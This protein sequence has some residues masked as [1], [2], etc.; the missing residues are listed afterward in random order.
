MN[1][2]R[3]TGYRRVVAGLA[4]AAAAVALAA[5]SSSS[6]AGSSA[7]DAAAK[8]YTLNFGY[9]GTGTG[10]T[11]PWGYA[12]SQG[13]LQQWLKP[14]GITLK[15]D[16]F[17]NGPLLTA[18]MLGG[19]VDAGVLGD[20]PALIAKSQ[21]L[22]AEFISQPEVGNEA[23]IVAQP[24][25]TS[26]SQLAG[27][28]IARQ[29]GSYLDRYLQGL[30]QEDGLFSKVKLVAMLTA[31][32][33]P[34]FEAGSLDAVVIQPTVWTTLEKTGK[35]YNVLAKSETTPS[36][37]GTQAAIVTDK[38]AAAHPNIA[39]AWNA[40]RVKSVQY[41]DAHAAGYYAWSAKQ[42]N[43]TVALEEQSAPLSTYPIP[44]FTAAG[45]KQLQGTLNFLVSTKQAK[46]SFTVQAWE[47]GSS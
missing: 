1:T 47:D 38:A 41:A 6:S 23:W 36:L 27:K 28:A 37:Q 35:K 33:N 20:T 19:S 15:L 10:L 44:N 31:Q 8:S 26:L 2:P 32:S 25:I 16:E 12:Y 7:N 43:T 42:A 3:R 40:V 45:T 11:G 21:G 13:L 4:A 34:A 14:Y 39:A 9:I 5:C 17:A 22:Q 30:L 18:A 24:S 46:S 29:Q